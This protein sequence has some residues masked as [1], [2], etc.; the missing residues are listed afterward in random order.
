M[1]TIKTV[2]NIAI[3]QH[4]KKIG[5]GNHKDNMEQVLKY[6]HCLLVELSESDFFNLVF[7]DIAQTKQLIDRAGSRKLA[8]IASVANN[9]PVT[10]L[11]LNWDLAD[12]ITKTNNFAR[13]NQEMPAILLRPAQGNE[14]KFGQWY[15]QDGSHRS[16]GYAMALKNKSLVY[17]PIKAFFVTNE[18]MLKTE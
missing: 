11:G 17:K 9:H 1:K 3:E 10:N 14:C 5:G 4:L 2:T 6:K 15:L 12:I 18:H 7:L 8:D 16:L 13:D